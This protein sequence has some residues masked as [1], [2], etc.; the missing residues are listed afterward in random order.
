MKRVLAYVPDLLFRS[1]VRG[2]ASAAGVEVVFASNGPDLAAKAASGGFDLAL[3]D[4]HA[5]GALAHLPRGVRVVG[6]H[7]HVDVATRRAAEAA[8]AEAYTNSAFVEA[9]PKILQA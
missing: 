7:S 4:L 6:F 8:G 9:L 2:T 1:R 3:V 5:P